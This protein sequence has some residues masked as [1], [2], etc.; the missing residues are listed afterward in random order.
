MALLSAGMVLAG[1]AGGG[2]APADPATA[3]E[4]LGI[5]DPE[6][7]LRRLDGSPDVGGRAGGDDVGR[8]VAGRSLGTDGLR[9][10]CAKA[11]DR[12]Q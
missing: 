10:P 3:L 1:C 9:K 2:P 6:W 12:E 11:S 4:V 5:P 7:R 8:R